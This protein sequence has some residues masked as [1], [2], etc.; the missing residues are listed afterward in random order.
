MDTDQDA[1]GQAVTVDNI[2]AA[3]SAAL[4]TAPAERNAAQLKLQEYEKDAVPGFLLS[5]LTICQQGGAVN[6]AKF[7]HSL[8]LSCDALCSLRVSKGTGV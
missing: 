4:G 3:L 5:L 1:L 8:Y 6:E 2:F 7:L